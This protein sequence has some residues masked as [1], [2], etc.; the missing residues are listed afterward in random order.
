MALVAFA[1]PS[2]RADVTVI[3]MSV[4]P[5][6]NGT[7]VMQDWGAVILRLQST[8]G[9]ILAVKFSGTDALG[10]PR[11]FFGRLGQRWTSSQGNGVYDQWSPGFLPQKNIGPSP[12]NFDS[13]FLGDGSEFLVTDALEE[14]NVLFPG[15]NPVPSDAFV[16]YGVG[17]RIGEESVGFLTG[18]YAVLPPAQRTSFDFAYLTLGG[19]MEYRGV[20]STAAGDFEIAGGGGVPDVPEPTSAIA[21]SVVLAS[22]LSRSRRVSDT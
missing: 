17:G 6:R 3:P 1:T 15:V 14:G 4:S 5:P 9:N 16:G 7:Q 19:S 20:V 18:G 12:L 11:G 13:H 8:S 22:L 21:L 2:S 10:R